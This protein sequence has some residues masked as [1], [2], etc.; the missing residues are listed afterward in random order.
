MGICHVQIK[1]RMEI[2]EKSGCVE[3][4]KPKIII[5]FFFFDPQA[6]TFCISID[7]RIQ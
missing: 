5:Y 3:G 4:S 7:T 6:F 2:I 1:M